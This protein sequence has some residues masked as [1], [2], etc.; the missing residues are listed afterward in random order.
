MHVLV[1]R[2]FRL[3]VLM[4]AWLFFPFSPLF[5][6]KVTLALVD[7]LGCILNYLLVTAHLSVLL[8]CKNITKWDFVLT[9]SFHALSGTYVLNA[10]VPN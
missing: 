2:Q 3:C 1:P 10:Y 7:F 4:E 5:F 6:C 8:C 9:H